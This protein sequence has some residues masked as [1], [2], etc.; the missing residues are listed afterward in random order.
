[1]AGKAKV[2]VT[3]PTVTDEQKRSDEAFMSLSEEAMAELSNGK[4][5]DED[6]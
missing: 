3:E 1:M 6:E 4:G 2:K 5:D